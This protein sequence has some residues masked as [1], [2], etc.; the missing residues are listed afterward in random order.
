M[1]NGSMNNR[2]KMLALLSDQGRWDYIPSGFF[3][4]FD[5]DHH[6]GS[7]AVKKHLE[8]YRHTGMDFV[9][10]Q[11]ERG[12]PRFSGL[13]GPAD[14]RR[15]RPV[16]SDYFDPAVEVVKGLVREVGSEALVILTLYSPFMLAGRTAGGRE[17]VE[18]HIAEDPDA[19]RA[20]MQVITHDLLTQMRRCVE[21]G[22]D[23]FYTSTQGG[24]AGRLSDAELFETCVRPFDLAVMEEADRT[25]RFNVLHV[26]DYH[27]PYSD[28]SRFVDYPGHVVNAGLEL[29][30]RKLKMQEVADMFGR[31]FM[32]GL[33]RK[34]VLAGGK[35]G[36]VR[37]AAEAICESA[38][39][40][41]IL[42]ADCTVPSDTDWDNLKTAVA[43]A[44]AYRS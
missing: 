25:C 37:A 26:C 22:I 2:E 10:L 36:E 35:A 28:I 41:F 4:H 14:W 43:V 1:H 24:E 7:A 29:T 38:P 39:D 32:G 11:Y 9:K 13:K 6:F 19:F 33:E 15:L 44:H 12:Y 8:F 5:S 18:R 17:I 3:L 42:A 40:R 20:G 16:E 31:P 27:Y 30:D 23:G 21:V 34:G